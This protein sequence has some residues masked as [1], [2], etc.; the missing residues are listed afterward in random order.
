MQRWRIAK[1][2]PWI[3]RGS[4][5][6]DVG[7]ADGELFRYGRGRITSGV[8]LDEQSTAVCPRVGVERRTGSFPSLVHDGETFDAITMLA[9]VEHAD[10]VELK[11]WA[12]ACARLLRANGRLIITV[13]SPAVDRILQVGMAMRLFDGMA[14]HQHTG[15]HP[16]SVLEVFASAGL[17]LE[18]A[19]RFQFGLNNLFVFRR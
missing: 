16:S 10:P 4:H 3:R 2:L 18:H 15:I 7:C 14:V 17:V 8:G 12:E 6:L 11:E 5:V 9:V 1:A 19:R 13:P